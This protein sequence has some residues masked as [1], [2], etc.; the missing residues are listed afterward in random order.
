MWYI[1]G[2]DGVQCGYV[3]R[4][5]SRRLLESQLQPFQIVTSLSDYAKAKKQ[6]DRKFSQ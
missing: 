5:K 6:W 4:S 3:S 2:F 1:F